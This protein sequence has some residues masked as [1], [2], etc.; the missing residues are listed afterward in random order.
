MNW[1]VNSSLPLTRTVVQPP[2]STSAP[3][4]S[5]W[6]KQKSCPRC[7]SINYH[8]RNVGGGITAIECP[9]LQLECC[10]LE[11]SKAA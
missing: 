8:E 2:M 5:I 6:E 7:G 11:A 9:V 10:R 4:A 1:R 3:R